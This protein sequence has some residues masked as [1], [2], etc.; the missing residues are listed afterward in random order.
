MWAYLCVRERESESL[1]SWEQT[2][3]LEPFPSKSTL[4]ERE[5]ELRCET[6]CSLQNS[7]ACVCARTAMLTLVVP[8]FGCTKCDCFPSRDGFCELGCLA[9]EAEQRCPEGS[10]HS[11]C[12]RRGS[13][14]REPARWCLG[15][16][17]PLLCS[18]PR[19]ESR[20]VFGTAAWWGC[21]PVSKAGR[22]FSQDEANLAFPASCFS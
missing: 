1:K 13:L 6:N 16:H 9:G 4:P 10:V 20:V 8:W 11:T 7:W 21:A 18:N 14:G 12:S 2:F 3:R 5:S 19:P 15:P 17:V 22:I